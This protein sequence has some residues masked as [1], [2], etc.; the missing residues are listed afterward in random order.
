LNRTHYSHLIGLKFFILI[1]WLGL[2]ACNQPET[3]RVSVMPLVDEAAL[4]FRGF[5]T[6][7]NGDLVSDIKKFT[8]T[9]IR[10]DTSDGKTEFVYISESQ[11][12]PFY[13]D[14][15]GTVWER[16]T[17]DLRLRVL[18]YDLSLRT[19]II[20]SYWEPLL[21]VNKGKG[22]K[23]EVTVDT[24]FDAIDRKGETQ[25]IRYLY[26]GKAR[27]EGWT[28]V[29][30]PESKKPYRAMTAY[31]YAAN[32]FITNATS[33]DSLFVSRGWARQ[34]FTPELGAI[35]YMTDFTK[36]EIGQKPVSLRGTWELMG[37]NIPN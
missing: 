13:T 1:A 17:Q 22:T 16:A 27:Y 23:W 7:V 34:Y 28:E 29:T 25:R 33:G 18:A 36:S 35:K 8:R 14:E 11:K 4:H 6:N 3:T 2:Q 15:A 24:T 19:P 26:K 30:V 10:R 5:V 20:L 9:A 12:T 32:T 21:K 37:K 31:W